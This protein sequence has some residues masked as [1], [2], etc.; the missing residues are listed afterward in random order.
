MYL[1]CGP[2][3]KARP[4]RHWNRDG[5]WVTKM[6]TW[7]FAGR[8]ERKEGRTFGLHVCLSVGCGNRVQISMECAYES[9][10][11]N[12]RRSRPC[13]LVL[14]SV[15]EQGK[16]SRK[17]GKWKYPI[18]CVRYK[19]LV[20]II[21]METEPLIPCFMFPLLLPVF[22]GWAGFTGFSGCSLTHQQYQQQQQQQLC[23]CSLTPLEQQEEQ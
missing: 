15:P 23:M 7:T 9:E 4:P 5:G 20:I 21:I 3:F 14:W 13:R 8:T 6:R 19:L 1:Q 22:T 18:V 12:V 17:E 10:R 11:F 2:L 16:W